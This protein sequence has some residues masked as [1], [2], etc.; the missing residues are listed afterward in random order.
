MSSMVV[1][2]GVEE[3]RNQLSFPRNWQLA[4]KDGSWC[5][6]DTACEVVPGWP[7]SCTAP[8]VRQRRLGAQRTN[9][10]GM[11]GT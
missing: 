10:G 1:G 4:H 3:G 9:K 8:R 6:R 7:A 2:V 5:R 11:K